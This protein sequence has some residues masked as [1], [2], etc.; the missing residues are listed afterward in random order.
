VKQ[1]ALLILIAFLA[2]CRTGRNYDA[3]GPRYSG[4]ARAQAKAIPSDTLRLVSFNVAWAAQIDSALKVLTVE[5]NLQGA[6]VLLLQEMDEPGTKRIANT[7]GMS[8]V[9]YPATF[10][11]KTKRDFGNAVLTRWPIIA[12]EK[13]MLPHIA[14]FR[15]TQRI[16]TAVTIQVGFSVVRVYAAHLGTPADISNASRRDQLEA[17]MANA[18]QYPRVIIGGDMNN[19]AVGQVAKKKGYLWP[20]ENNDPTIRVWNWDHFFLKGFTVPDSAAAGTIREN[21]KASDH[22]PIWARAILPIAGS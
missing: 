1:R 9:Y 10:S 16:A 15:R 11:T 5:P 4:Q 2:G 3:E 13:I 8:Y 18:A 19:R 14:R 21:R 17:I 20:T 7:L 6:D 22:R 12:D